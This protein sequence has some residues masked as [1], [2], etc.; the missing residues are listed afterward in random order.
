MLFRSHLK[1][2]LVTVTLQVELVISRVNL[3]VSLT[4]T[5]IPIGTLTLVGPVLLYVNVLFVTLVVPLNTLRDA[6]PQPDAAST[7]DP[8]TLTVL[9]VPATVKVPNVTS[10]LLPVDVALAKVNC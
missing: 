4:F 1:T 5:A 3:S 7:I 6:P 2:V 10:K 9:R 8:I